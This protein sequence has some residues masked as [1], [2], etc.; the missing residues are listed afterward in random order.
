MRKV[1]VVSQ[2]ETVAFLECL[3]CLREM[4]YSEAGTVLDSIRTRLR[5]LKAEVV[6]EHNN[7]EDTRRERQGDRTASSQYIT[8]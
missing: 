3:T 5:D 7:E 6:A 2:P 1:F 8:V 4:S